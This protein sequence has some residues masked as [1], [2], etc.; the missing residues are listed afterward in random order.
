MGSLILWGHW[1]LPL[2]IQGINCPE[3]VYVTVMDYNP[4][5]SVLQG[6]WKTSV[7]EKLIHPGIGCAEACEWPSEVS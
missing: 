6:S 7:Q 5:Q 3:R 2:H 1:L 4:V